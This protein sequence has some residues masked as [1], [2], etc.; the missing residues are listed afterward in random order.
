L[1]ALLTEGK[2]KAEVRAVT[3]YGD[4]AYCKAVQRYNAQGL[5][6]LRDLRHHNLGPLKLL[7]DAQILLLAQ[8]IRLSW[9]NCATSRGRPLDFAQGVLWDGAKVKLW[10]KENFD[11]EIHTGR[12]YEFLSQV[13]FSRVSPR[14][15]HV[16]ADEEAQNSF[17][18]TR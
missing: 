5:V 8:Q 2:S 12:A 1:I 3:R 4:P 7:S 18:K 14:P 9:P 13:G 16:D 15:R 10:L 6:G 17:K 11:L